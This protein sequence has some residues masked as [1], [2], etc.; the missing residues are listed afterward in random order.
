MKNSSL[1]HTWTVADAKA[2]LSEI[3]RKANSTPQYIGTKKT[4]VLI[5]QETWQELNQP[6]EPMGKWLVK[7]LHGLDELELPDRTDPARE[8]PFQ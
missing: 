7:N 8:I 5:P 6:K 1:Q 2:R 4:Y 3:L